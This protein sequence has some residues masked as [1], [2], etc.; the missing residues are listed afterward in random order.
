MD[1]IIIEL[2]NRI[3]LLENKVVRQDRAFKKL[4]KDLMPE[5][6]KKPRAPSGFAKPTYLSPAMC[7]FLD[8]PLGSE[9]ARTEVT[10]RVLGY[11]KEKALQNTEQKRVIDIDDRMRKLLNPEVDEQVTYFSIQRLLKGHYIKPVTEEASPA[12]VVEVIPDTPKPVT[13]AVKPVKASTKKK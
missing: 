2:Q 3:T 13:A 6:E 7:E 9:L 5:V 4:K 10:K 1:T 12:L 11:V 8:I